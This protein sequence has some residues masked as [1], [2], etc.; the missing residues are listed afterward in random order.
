[1]T[2]HPESRNHFPG[3][4]ARACQ[5][6]TSAGRDRP[7]RRRATRACM[8]V[9]ALTGVLGLAGTGMASAAPQRPGQEAV[10]LAGPPATVLGI[11]G[12]GQTTTTRSPFETPLR[13]L[14]LDE[15]GHVVAGAPVTFRIQTGYAGLTGTAAFP[16]GAQSAEVMTGTNGRADSLALTAGADVGPLRVEASVPGATQTATFF[17]RVGYAPAAQ[18]SI[19]SGDAQSALAGTG[20]AHPLVVQVLDAH[21]YPVLDGSTVTFQIEP[22]GPQPGSAT[23]A[24]GQTTATAGINASDG[25]ATSPALVAG[26]RAGTIKITAEVPQSPSAPEAVFTAT[27]LPQAP[28]TLEV[29]GGNYQF[30]SAGSLFPSPLQVR[31]LDQ[32]GH[33]IPSP[34]AHAKVTG[35]ATIYGQTSLDVAGDQDGVISMPLV[36]ADGGT[37]PVT[38]TVTAGTAS[39]TFHENLPAQGR[40]I[41]TPSHGD[42]QET[43]P[44]Q[45]FYGL[46]GVDVTDGGDRVIPDFPL[47]FTADGPA[48]FADG[49][50]TAT[51]I[52]SPHNTNWAPRLY[53]TNASGPVTVTVT[54]AGS[55]TSATFHLKVDDID[56][57]IILGGD[58]QTAPPNTRPV[59]EHPFPAPL[60]VEAIQANDHPASGEPVTYTVHGPAVFVISDIGTDTLQVVT[61]ADGRPQ[62]PSTPSTTRPAQS[63]SPPVAPTSALSPSPKPWPATDLAATGPAACGHRPGSLSTPGARCPHCPAPRPGPFR[64]NV[65]VA[66]ERK[67]PDPCRRVGPTNGSVSFRW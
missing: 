46:L 16:G 12:D 59:L 10:S 8:L 38:V 47:I 7:L 45:P 52:S 6:E 22:T 28:T 49:S 30:G 33:P 50:T 44:T 25:H 36:A 24:D 2:T 53:A 54:I 13:V 18:V 3:R 61:G 31:V 58:K 41:I 62:P 1:M 20:F 63:P 26:S 29:A 21:G 15:T 40:V 34:A 42:G 64:R 55:D 57:L 27:T 51:V 56:R 43:Q 48:A 17:L 4:P 11:S 60:T 23:F 9:L 67:R 39:V 19:V 65:S 66:D 5:K 14:V 32:A 37:G 35:P